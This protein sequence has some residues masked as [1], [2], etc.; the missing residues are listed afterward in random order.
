M[1]IWENAVLTDK[2]RNL[3]AKLIGGTSLKITRAVT[4][5]GYVTPGLLSK[6]TAV[7]D[8]K[9]ELTFRPVSYPETGKCAVTM[10]LNNEKV[11]AGYAALQLGIY[12]QD[13]D[14]GE[15]LYVL[16]QAVDKDH[17]TQI[18]ASS[19]IPFNA[20]WTFYF[21]YGQADAV[22]VVVDPSNTVSYAQMET[23]V[24]QAVAVAT[25]EEIDAVLGG[26]GA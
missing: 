22:T 10:V 9:Q 17:G 13:P 21:Q 23:Y 26:V 1:N 20:E 19:E 25:I 14:E 15:I 11:S 4:G 8:P 2:G 12:A 18:P 6:Q 24:R 3:Q 7:T 16:A 5:A